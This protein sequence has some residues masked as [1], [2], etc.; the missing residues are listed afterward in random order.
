MAECDACLGVRVHTAS[1]RSNPRP[2]ESGRGALAL[3]EDTQAL[4]GV[5][6]AILKGVHR[7]RR[8]SPLARRN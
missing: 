6:E 1:S 4:A 2:R 5:S 3:G 7:S 8:V